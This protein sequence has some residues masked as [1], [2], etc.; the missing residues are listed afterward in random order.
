[1]KAHYPVE[2]AA[3]LLTVERANSDKVAQYVADTRHMGIAV[4]P[5]DINESRGDFT[6][7]GEVVR[8]GLHGVKNVG[9]AAVE[10]IVA[11]RE[12]AGPFKDLFDFCRRCESSLINKRA[13]EHLVKAGAFDAMGER[14]TLL[15]NVES[16]MK[17][18]TAQRESDAAG[19]MALFAAEELKP[20]ALQAGEELSDLDRLKLE[21][22]SL[23]LYISAHPMRSYPGLAEAASCAVDHLEAWLHEQ[24]SGGDTTGRLK[25][26]LAG[27]LQNV[28]KRPT[29]KGSMMARF[30]IAD[31]SGSREVVAFSR[32]FDEIAP[33]LEED[34]PVVLVA[35]ASEDGEAVR[36]VADRLIRWDARDAV[37]E[38]AVL[39]FDPRE[40]AEHQLLELRSRIDETSGTTPVQLR[41]PS[42]RGVVTWWAE[43]I[44]VD[45]SRLGELEAHCP[46][47]RTSVTID[48]ARLLVDRGPVWSRKSQAP[49][50][51]DVPF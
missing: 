35:E 3:A 18:G 2:F 45:A 8:F 29:R 39:R 28:A 23:G 17:W 50:R 21:K 34:A 24:R 44:S 22:E 7:V 30:E 25:V 36:L 37:P 33:L 6:P 48:R 40:I 4:L 38:V 31:E 42:S 16:A 49:A 27:I 15:A 20:P 11:E 51:A 46:W 47:L 13:L 41:F 43:G 9:D 14:A 1:M 32:I 19:Q 10:H 12:R 26:V 5:P